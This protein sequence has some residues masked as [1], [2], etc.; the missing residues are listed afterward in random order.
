MGIAKLMTAMSSHLGIT[1]YFSLKHVA[2]LIFGI[3][4]IRDVARGVQRVP[5]HPRGSVGPLRGPLSH[6]CRVAA[7]NFL[8]MRALIEK[9]RT[10]FFF[11]KKKWVE[12][13]DSGNRERPNHC[14]CAEVF[15]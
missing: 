5:M 9:Y 13:D 12:A 7:A 11:V 14:A 1:A 4:V 8:G 6:L 2:I 15:P 10:Q 3:T